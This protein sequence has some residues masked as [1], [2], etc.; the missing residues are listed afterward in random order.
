[1]TKESSKTRGK[2]TPKAPAAKDRKTSK[3]DILVSLLRQANGASIDDL[4]A[5]CGWQKHSVRGALAGTLR[6]K[7]YSVSSEVIDGSRRY[8]IAEAQA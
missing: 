2:S 7:G 3:L 1:M 6:K 8:R 4:A 5:A